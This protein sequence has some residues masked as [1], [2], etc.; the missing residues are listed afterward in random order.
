MIKMTEIQT[1]KLRKRKKH[2]RHEAGKV[3]QGQGLEGADSQHYLTVKR[4]LSSEAYILSLDK[5]EQWLASL[6]KVAEVLT[7]GHI[8]IPWEF[9]FKS[10][11]SLFLAF[12]PLIPATPELSSQQKLP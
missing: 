8:M 11:F 7:T 9:P 12:P 10:F 3:S 1:K 6:I 5:W 2:A 4:Y